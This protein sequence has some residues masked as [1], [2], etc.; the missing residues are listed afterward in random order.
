MDQETNNNLEGFENA[1]EPST[2]SSPTLHNLVK[3]MATQNDVLRQLLQGQQT[4]QQLLQQQQHQLREYPIYQPQVVNYQEPNEETNEENDI[5]SDSLLLPSQLPMK[6]REVE[7]RN[8][9]CSLDPIDLTGWEISCAE[10]IPRR[11]HQT[12]KTLDLD[13]VFR[14]R[15]LPSIKE[16]M[17]Q[18]GNFTYKN[19]S[20][21]MPIMLPLENNQPRGPSDTNHY[22]NY[23][24]SKQKIECK[25]QRKEHKRQ[26]QGA[27]R[28]SV[29][30]Q[31]Q[32]Q[33][34][35]GPRPNDQ[36]FNHGN[37]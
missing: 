1:S 6:P 20:V 13:T 25:R 23:A 9:K 19:D 30:Q 4:I 17:D 14:A 3:L 24:T 22:I 18:K 11:Q 10:F 33:Q 16:K 35:S 27:T 32:Q 28:L 7:T 5:Y 26:Q 34:Q 2:T 15:T 8:S 29:P 12:V 31:Q 21:G 36:Q 37:N